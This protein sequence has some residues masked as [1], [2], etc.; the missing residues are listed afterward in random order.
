MEAFS[1]HPVVKKA[2][3][4][5]QLMTVTEFLRE[6]RRMV[7]DFVVGRVLTHNGGQ[8]AVSGL[9]DLTTY[10]LLHRNDFG[11]DDA[12]V[13]ACILYALSCNLSD[14]IRPW[15]ASTTSWPSRAEGRPATR[16]V[17]QRRTRSRMRRAARGQAEAQGVESSEGSQPGL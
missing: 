6:V 2:N 11:M 13:G 15:C 12:P 1:K 3:D 8:E 9:D 5:D 17:A 4:P 10:Y 14:P 7:V 16:M